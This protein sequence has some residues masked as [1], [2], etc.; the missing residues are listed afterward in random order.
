LSPESRVTPPY[1]VFFG[2]WSVA[3]SLVILV[4]AAVPLPESLGVDLCAWR[5]MLGQ[6]CPGCGLSRSVRCLARGEFMQSVTF[7]PFGL[8]VLPYAVVAASR[9][10][11]PAT[12]RARIR[13]R[14]DR[15]RVVIRRV[16]GVL[17]AL[18]LGF[19]VVRFILGKLSIWIPF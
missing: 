7:H 15:R 14:M 13:E 5:A 8:L 18:F 17:L 3:V 11:W 19:G 12:F 16:G 10:L 9:L 1:E 4:G 6:A 2:R